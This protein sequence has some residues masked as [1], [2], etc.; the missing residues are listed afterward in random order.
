M[1][2]QH[3]TSLAAE[4]KEV[5]N[6]KQREEIKQQGKRQAL[7]ALLSSDHGGP[8][9]TTEHLIRVCNDLCDDS[10]RLRELLSLEI[11]YQKNVIGETLALKIFT[12]SSIYC[13]RAKCRSFHLKY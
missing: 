1:E 10:N 3:D 12:A 9:S 5:L 11:S 7:V 2:N 13:P 6:A 8:I 4:K